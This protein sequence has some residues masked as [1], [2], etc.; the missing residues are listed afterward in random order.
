MHQKYQKSLMLLTM[1]K[2]TFNYELRLGSNK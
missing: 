2:W 1:K